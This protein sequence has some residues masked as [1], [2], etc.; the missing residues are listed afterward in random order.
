M[1]L[2]YIGKGIFDNLTST[3][4]DKPYLYP[5]DPDDPQSQKVSELSSYTGKIIGP[6]KV[7]A[8][9]KGEKIDLSTKYWYTEVP[10]EPLTSIAEILA[11]ITEIET[12]SI[13]TPEDLEKVLAENSQG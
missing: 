9:K 5:Y 11:G 2:S 6:A 13:D 8:V 12:P 7:M 10:G 1:H 3:E 4:K